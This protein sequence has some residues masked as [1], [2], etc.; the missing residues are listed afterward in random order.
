MQ[1]SEEKEQ[2][3]IKLRRKFDNVYAEFKTRPGYTTQIRLTGRW[4]VERR[5]FKNWAA[6]KRFAE[7]NGCDV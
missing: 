7:E 4:I 6:F 5:I 2:I 3:L 1:L